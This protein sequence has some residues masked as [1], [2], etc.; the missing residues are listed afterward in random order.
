M[1]QLYA[2]EKKKEG[3]SEAQKHMEEYF[4]KPEN[5]Y[6]YEKNKIQ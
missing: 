3:V 2:K 4:S 1:E 6:F 5:I